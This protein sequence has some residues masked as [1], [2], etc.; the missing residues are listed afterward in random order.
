MSRRWTLAVGGSDPFEMRE[1]ES[2]CWT[3]L[4]SGG[5]LPEV[6]KRALRRWTFVVGGGDIFQMRESRSRCWTYVVSGGGLL[7][8]RRL[9]QKERSERRKKSERNERRSEE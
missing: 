2:R 8:P 4:A 6:E 9:A 1:S 3:H 5:G 7:A